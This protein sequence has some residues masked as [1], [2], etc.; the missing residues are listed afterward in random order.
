MDNSSEQN[1]GQKQN[2]PDTYV[3][4]EFQFEKDQRWY[5]TNMTM[6]EHAQML[7]KGML[8][9][10]LISRCALFYVEGTGVGL[11]YDFNLARQ[12]QNP[13]IVKGE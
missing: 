3:E 10:Q 7:S 5:K 11:V 1:I 9:N 13:W 6:Q 2:K 8:G 4:V 12:G